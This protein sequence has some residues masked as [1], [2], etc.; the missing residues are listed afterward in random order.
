MLIN[1]LAEPLIR[2]IDKRYPATEK[3]YRKYMRRF[4]AG[5]NSLTGMIRKTVGGT[6]GDGVYLLDPSQYT[7][8]CPPT[9]YQSRAVADLYEIPRPDAIDW[10]YAESYMDIVITRENYYVIR[11][12]T[13]GNS[14]KEFI[15]VAPLVKVEITPN[16]H[17]EF[18][19]V[20]PGAFGIRI[21]ETCL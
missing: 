19:Y 11:D 5:L 17:E 7:T 2:E 1:M 10:T 16:V 20:G 12:I 6:H 9:E 15:V 21:E 13:N 18:L 4:Y 3:K 8:N 14:L